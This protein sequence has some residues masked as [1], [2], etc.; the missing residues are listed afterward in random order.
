MLELAPAERARIIEERRQSREVVSAAT[1]D[2]RAGALLFYGIDCS[3]F[4]NILE[5]A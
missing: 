5:G 4:H 2:A 1:Q 3:T